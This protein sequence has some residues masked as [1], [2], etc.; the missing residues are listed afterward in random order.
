MP[1]ILIGFSHVG[2][3]I[4]GAAL[5]KA[6]K[7]KFTD[8]DAVIE[9]YYCQI[10]GE[11]LACRLI[12]Q[13][14]GNDHFR[15]LE[16]ACLKA[17]LNPAPCVLAVGGGTPM[18]TENQILIARG[19]VIYLQA[20][21]DSVFERIMTHGRPAYFPQDADSYE[22][23]MQVWD[24]REPIYCKLAQHSVENFASIDD[25]VQKI[26]HTLEGERVK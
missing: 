23:F 10:H 11:K 1:I 16:N 7:I 3:S 20:A 24:E 4:I 12:M 21:R 17:V 15:S 22:A 2:K 19:T 5:A 14:H 13:Q 9:A 6:L 8:L 26:L 18:N 25:C